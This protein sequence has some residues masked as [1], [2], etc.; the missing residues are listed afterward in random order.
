M[1]L[2]RVAP[3]DRGG[4]SESRMGMGWLRVPRRSNESGLCRNLRLARRRFGGA[5]RRAHGDVFDG[6]KML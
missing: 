5:L 3:R 2:G 6:H 4:A 1:Q